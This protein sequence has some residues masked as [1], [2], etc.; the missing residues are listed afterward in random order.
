LLD[1]A[2]IAAYALAQTCLIKRSPDR[3]KWWHKGFPALVERM[4]MQTASFSYRP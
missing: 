3:A 1:L 4:K 2:D